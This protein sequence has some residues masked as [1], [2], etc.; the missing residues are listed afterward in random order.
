MTAA[1][2]HFLKDFYLFIFRERVKEGERE[3]ERHQS[4]ASHV[5][6]NEDLAHNPGMCPDWES[7]RQH[8]GLQA[9]A[10]STEP[11]QPGQT[12]AFSSVEFIGDIGKSN[13]RELGQ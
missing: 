2:N 1:F 9:S 6:P 4:I 12:T 7:D 5:P 3:G 13:F 10:Q 11:C 8:F